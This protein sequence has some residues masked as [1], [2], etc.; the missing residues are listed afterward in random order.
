MIEY[1]TAG[2]EKS[3]NYYGKDLLTERDTWWT[4]FIRETP[5][6]G[7]YNIPS[8]MEVLNSTAVHKT[9]GFK[10]SGRK[11]NADP[12]RRGDYLLPGLYKFKSSLDETLEK[13]ENFLSKSTSRDNKS[14]L[15]VG[16]QDKFLAKSDLS[17][18]KYA[19]EFQMDSKL[20]SK[21]AVFKSKSS[22]FPTI[23]F[24]PK[25]GPSPTE[26]HVA[27]KKGIEVTSSFASGTSR[28]KKPHVLKTPGPGAYTKMLQ[29]PLP[30]HA[31]EINLKYNV[32]FP[33]GVY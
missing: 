24:Q 17:P 4:G 6:P 3:E 26:Y 12:T 29:H 23:Y 21:D 10:S 2:D 9:Y 8:M 20:A 30:K 33:P 7:A 31:K 1:S 15:V 28:F 11:R 27:K 13:Q 16:I 5:D 19:K 32:F 22:R 18:L 25:K 14:A